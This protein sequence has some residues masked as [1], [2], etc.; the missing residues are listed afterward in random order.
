[1]NIF[2]KILVV[3][4]IAFSLGLLAGAAHG[5]SVNQKA[6]VS[7]EFDDGFY[8]GYSI[9]VPMFEA[10]GYPVTSCIVTGHLNTTGYMTRP[11]VV[12]LDTREFWDP[13]KTKKLR[14]EICAHTRNHRDLASVTLTLAQ[15]SDE[16]LGGKADLEAIVKHPVKNFAYPFGHHKNSAVGY[17]MQGFNSAGTVYGT[18]GTSYYDNG[19]DA[20]TNPFIIG[21]YPFTK[22]TSSSYM[23]AV[24]NYAISHQKWVVIVLHSVDDSCNVPPDQCTSINSS[25]ITD[26]IQYTQSKVAAN[27]ITVVTREQGLE[28][29][30]ID[31]LQK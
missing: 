5:Q 19:T 24:I 23:H 15:Q 25:Q 28:T 8:S 21:R 7:F 27:Q 9:G 18:I 31:Q 13:T 11:E 6:M 1:M 10:A 12:D 17:V 4:G 30:G 14:H 16:I 29:L 26:L 2:K 20:A 22:T 3:L